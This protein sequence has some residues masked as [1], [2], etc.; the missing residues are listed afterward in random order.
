MYLRSRTL[1]RERKFRSELL[2][3]SSGYKTK[4]RKAYSNVHNVGCELLQE[5]KETADFFFIHSNLINWLIKPV[6]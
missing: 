4:A 6:R 5:G 1:V 3:P 2:P